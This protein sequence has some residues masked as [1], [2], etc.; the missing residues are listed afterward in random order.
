MR[1]GTVPS[2]PGF[3]F[4]TMRRAS[5]R[6][7]AHPSR[8]GAP[9]DVTTVSIAARHSK[10]LHQTTSDSCI[11]ITLSPNKMHLRFVEPRLSAVLT[12]QQLSAA[13]PKRHRDLAE[14][15]PVTV[16]SQFHPI[17][18]VQMSIGPETLCARHNQRFDSARWIEF[19]C[20]P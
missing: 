13:A 11:V 6:L 3:S 1:C 4:R 14:Y 5:P 20:V 17:L 9:R 15:Q 10:L 7:H 8:Q 12:H 18:V 2:I 19:I 16:S